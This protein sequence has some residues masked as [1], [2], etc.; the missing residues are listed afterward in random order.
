MTTISFAKTIPTSSDYYSYGGAILIN[1]SGVTSIIPHFKKN[2][3]KIQKPKSKSRQAATPSDKFDNNIVDLK[4]G[5][6]EITV[7]GWLDDDQYD[8]TAT[9]GGS[10]QL[11]DT[12]AAWTVGEHNGATLEIISGTGSGQSKTVTLNT[13][14]LLTVSSSWATE[15]DNTSVYKII[16]T[17]WTKLWQIRAMCSTG[18]ALTTFTIGDISFSSSTQEAFIEELTGNINPDDTGEIY[19]NSGDGIVRIDISMNFFIGDAR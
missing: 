16:K 4:R 7:R 14:T 13:P 3:I 8:G 11:L 12:G 5:T 15:P 19:T 9:S 2:L 18:G 17:A 6:D 1:F 10:S